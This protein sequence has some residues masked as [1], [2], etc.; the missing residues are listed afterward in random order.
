MTIILFKAANQGLLESWCDAQNNNN[1]ILYNSNN[2][3]DIIGL[4]NYAINKSVV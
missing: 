1:I 4:Y 2:K 3:N